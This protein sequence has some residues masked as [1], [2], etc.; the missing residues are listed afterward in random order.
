MFHWEVQPTLQLA[1]RVNHMECSFPTRY[2]AFK[3]QT[4]L[5]LE[6][7]LRDT[8]YQ[9]I[10]D[11]AKKLHKETLIHMQQFWS[12]LL[13]QQVDMGQLTLLSTMITHRRDEGNRTFLTALQHRNNDRMLLTKYA[14]FL[15]QV[16]LEPEY[17]EQLRSL[18]KQE[19]EERRKNAMR[20]ARG[21]A[22]TNHDQAVT[23]L[24]R[25]QANRSSMARSTSRIGSNKAITFLTTL[26]CF[27]SVEV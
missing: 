15:E 7:N 21:G 4:R 22:G 14:G 19:M 3:L 2:H 24:L 9:R 6:L 1:E 17:A 5:K 27:S 18:T 10:C 26:C 13:S 11:Q 23:D 20:G 25:V 8:T 12:K 16:M